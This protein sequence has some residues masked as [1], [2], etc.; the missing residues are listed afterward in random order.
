VRLI[1]VAV[2][3]SNRVFHADVPDLL[4]GRTWRD[5][6]FVAI[7]GQNCWYSL[8]GPVRVA[9]D[10]ECVTGGGGGGG[11]G[12]GS[13]SPTTTKETTTKKTTTI[14]ASTTSGPSTSAGSETTTTIFWFLITILNICTFFCLC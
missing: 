11:G 7:L 14:L 6:Q 10:L 1:A 12:G 3:S 4:T 9:D 13:G 2:S 8:M 5:L